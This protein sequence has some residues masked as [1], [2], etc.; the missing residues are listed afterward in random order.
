ME[1]WKPVFDSVYEVSSE[2]RVKRVM[3]GKGTKA[4]TILKQPVDSAGYC[5]T[6][7][8]I[9]GKRN[10]VRNHILV[11]SLFIGDRPDGM[12]IN[13]IDGDKT[14]N[15]AVNLEYISKSEN[16]KHAYALGL[17][18]PKK[19]KISEEDVIKIRQMRKDGVSQG[20]IGKIFQKDQGHISAIVNRKIWRNIK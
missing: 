20:V 4:G 6:T 18:G 15:A 12:E 5:V 17:I 10:P 13:H 1:T 9:N 11:A 3:G 14:N 16:S 19:G 7:F 8:C 2:G